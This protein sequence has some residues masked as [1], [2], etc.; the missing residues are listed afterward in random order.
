MKYELK[1]TNLLDI[2]NTAKWLIDLLKQHNADK[3]VIAF[4]GQMGVGK[5]TLIKSICDA[6]N[7]K[8]IVNSPTFAIV[9]QYITVEGEII[10]HFDFYRISKLSE[11]VDL[12]FDEYIYS[13]NLCLIEWPEKIEQLLPEKFVKVDIYE[14]ADSTRTIEVDFF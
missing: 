13:E 6:L 10:Y 9:N 5:T 8:D 7:V 2:Q 1:N 11:A 12:G 3:S 4:Y 14:N